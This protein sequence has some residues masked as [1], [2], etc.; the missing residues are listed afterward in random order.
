MDYMVLCIY[1]HKSI[2]FAIHFSFLKENLK[3]QTTH[4]D[5]TVSKKG[6]QKNYGCTKY[7][8]I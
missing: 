6:K 8:F 5:E 2:L 7:F 1:T 4:T 3:S